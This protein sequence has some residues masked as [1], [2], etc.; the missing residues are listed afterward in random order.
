MVHGSS[1]RGIRSERLASRG[2]GHSVLQ[3]AGCSDQADPGQRSERA[4]PAR[5]PKGA[6]PLP[7]ASVVNAC[8]LGNGADSRGGA[9]TMSVSMDRVDSAETNAAAILA[10][11]AGGGTTSYHVAQYC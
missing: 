7:S 9:S 4:G 11:C 6:S 8:A 10:R 5:G 3:V 2:G 1:V